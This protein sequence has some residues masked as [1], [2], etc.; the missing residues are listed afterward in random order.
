MKILNFV[1]FFLGLCVNICALAASTQEQIKLSH[2]Q[3]EE[4]LVFNVFLPSGYS[5]DTQKEYIT[6]FDFHPYSHTYLSGMHDWMSHNGEWPWLKTIIVTPAYGNR[7][8]MLFD[9]T[10][11]TTPLLDF[12]D[13]Q[14]FPHIDKNYRTNGFRIMSGFRTNGTIVLSALLNKPNMINAYIAISPELKD[15]Y[16]RILSTANEVLAKLNDKPRFLLFSHGTNV[17]EQHQM[18]SYELLHE[19]L[20]NRAPSKLNWHYQHFAQNYFMS[21]P[22]VSVIMGVEKL[23]DDI[24]TG[25]PPESEIA[26]KGVASIVA[27]YR[28]LS[29]QKYGF[30]VSPKNSINRLGEY[31]LGTDP[32]KGIAVLEHLIKLYP[33]DSYSY[34][35]LASAYSQIGDYEAAVKHQETAVELAKSRQTWHQNKHKSALEDYRLKL[36]SQISN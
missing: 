16:V 3:F 28:Y 6:L 26:Q 27:H 29:E 17:K 30:E 10:G 2:S 33:E 22:L 1:L 21:L 12:F 9:E 18:G 8:G 14:L 19:A 15:D 5:K 36:N 24:H 34:H 20:K 7:A 11:K 23:F 31:T 25:L 32:V 35:S 4:P 13:L